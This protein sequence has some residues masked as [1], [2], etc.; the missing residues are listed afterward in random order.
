[1]ELG[2]G[3]GLTGLLLARAGTRRVYITDIGQAVL[4]NC[5]CNVRANCHPPIPSDA[6]K[7]PPPLSPPLELG[8]AR[9][10]LG[11]D[12]GLR[13][14]TRSRCGNW[15]GGHCQ[16]MRGG[17]T[18]RG[19]P[20]ARG[21]L[22]LDGLLTTC[23][24]CMRLRCTALAHHDFQQHPLD[25]ANSLLLHYLRFPAVA[26]SPTPPPLIV[27][28]LAGAVCGGHHLRRRHD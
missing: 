8:T 14:L 13:L 23:Q 4:A 10:A 15:T 16:A 9:D 18:M 5:E 27:S 2:S 19:R 25:C 20:A 7:V 1:M 12:S 24:S 22:P 3:T 6:I 28:P 21:M 17:R 26:E 11:G